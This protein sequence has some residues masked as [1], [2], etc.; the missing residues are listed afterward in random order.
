MCS[1]SYIPTHEGFVL[2]H[3]RDELPQRQSS[4]KLIEAG[5][6]IFPQDLKAGGT[7]MGAHENGWGACLLNGGKE[8]YL[9]R[10]AY[11]QSRGLVILEFLSDAN[12][13]RFQKLQWESFEPF[14]LI[15]ANSEELWQLQHDPQGHSWRNL[16]PQKPHFWS[17]TKLYHREIRAAREERFRHWWKAEQSKNAQTI[18]SFHLQ[19]QL[20]PNEGGLL[21]DDGFPLSTVSFTQF[22]LRDRQYHFRY[23]HLL[24]K[25]EDLK[26][27]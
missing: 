3:N 20:S 27:W 17:S 26:I 12:L 13:T 4:S 21:L 6:G 18:K 5:S 14:T 22:E 24:N 2:S 23:H 8:P 25:S 11:P 15:L 9:R 19:K 16:D 1:L 7:W 10:A